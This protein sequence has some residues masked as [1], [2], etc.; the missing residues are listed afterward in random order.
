MSQPIPAR[1]PRTRDERPA[2]TESR[3][4]AE[5]A[6]ACGVVA[7]VAYALI[8]AAPLSSLP[9]AIASSVFGVSLAVA[10]AGLY[11]VL[12][13]DRSTVS[14]KI[15]LGANIAAAITV[16]MMLLG[17]LAFKRWLELKFPGS[18]ITPS[19]AAYQAANGLQLG[20]DVAW[21]AFLS[22][23]TFLLAVNMW[24]HP[25]F[26]KVF[27]VTGCSIAAMLLTINLAAFPESPSE[28][29]L[30]DVGPLVGLWYLVTAIRIGFSLRWVDARAAD[31]ERL[32]R[33]EDHS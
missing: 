20:F 7:C 17:Q 6:V 22:L 13:L 15:G 11:E 1:P 24:K 3:T 14:L 12:R 23:G 16:T 26:G 28:T 32:P 19:S 9:A 25:R 31:V 21:D 27:A 18:A 2:Q 33:H 10:S 29:G 5:L 8:V 30:F 4:W